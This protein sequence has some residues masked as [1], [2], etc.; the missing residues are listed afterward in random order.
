ML[1]RVRSIS[2]FSPSLH[3]YKLRWLAVETSVTA[4]P[5]CKTTMYP[6]LGY[7]E[8]TTLTV[9]PVL[10]FAS[11]NISYADGADSVERGA[12][13]TRTRCTKCSKYV[14]CCTNND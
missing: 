11:R 6:D 10:G 5:A 14:C 8:V 1:P 7:T 13:D 2:S 12:A 4:V 9:A 3:Y